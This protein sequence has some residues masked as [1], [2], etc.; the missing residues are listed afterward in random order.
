MAAPKIIFT[1]R[2]LVDHNGA[3]SNAADFDPPRIQRDVSAYHFTLMP[4]D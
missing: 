4:D 3:T 1:S 2:H